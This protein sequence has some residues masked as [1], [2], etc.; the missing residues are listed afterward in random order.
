MEI[1]EAYDLA[2]S[3]RGAAQLAGCDHKTVAHWVRQRDLGMLP[4][5]DRQRPAM[6]GQFQAKIDELVDR[7][8]GKI[9]ADKAH[10]K[11]IVLGYEGAPRTTRRWVAASKRRWRREHGRVT[12]P[13]M[14]EPGLWMQF[15]V[16]H[17]A[18]LNR[19]EVEDHHRLAVAAVG[20]KLRA[21]GSGRRRGRWQAALTTTGLVGTARRPGPGKQD[22]KVYV[23]NQRSKAP[24]CIH[25]PET[26][27]I[28]AGT[29]LN[30]AAGR[31]AA[32]T[33][34]RCV[35]GRPGGHEEC[36]RRTRGWPQGYSWAPALSIDSVVNVGTVLA[37]PVRGLGGQ[38][39]RLPTAS[40]RGG[41]AVLVRAGESPVHGEG[42]Q[43][44]RS[45]RTGR[46][47]GRW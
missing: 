4:R 8:H 27:R 5:V 17:E 32:G 6:H 38:A 35:E 41:A 29:R 39:R 7:S 3:L 18:L 31:T 21:A 28:W 14:P 16:R 22:R 11:L 37:R 46:P 12:R 40:D 36:L 25:R 43:Q 45:G 42:R 44:V 10:E 19:V 47:G 33:L 34:G 30:L 26:W 9:R 20:L 15:D 23:R 1:L 2:G 24:Q 13:W